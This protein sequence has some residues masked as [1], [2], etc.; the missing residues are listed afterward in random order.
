VTGSACD[1]AVIT[2]CAAANKGTLLAVGASIL[3]VLAVVIQRL[4]YNPEVGQVGIARM[5]KG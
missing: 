2:C 4:I 1:I 5:S 3:S